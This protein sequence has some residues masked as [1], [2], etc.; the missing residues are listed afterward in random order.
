MWQAC[1][2]TICLRPSKHTSIQS[3]TTVRIWRHSSALRYGEGTHRAQGMG[4]GI[5]TSSAARKSE[6]KREEE[7]DYAFAMRPG[8]VKKKSTRSVARAHISVRASELYEVLC[9]RCRGLRSTRCK[10]PT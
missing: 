4:R 9:V 10:Q 3:R 7:G 1:R 5:M 2:S 6:A 8:E